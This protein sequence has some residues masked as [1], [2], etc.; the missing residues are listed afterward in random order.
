MFA[1]TKQARQPYIGTPIDDGAKLRLSQSIQIKTISGQDADAFSSFDQFLRQ[2]FELVFS[3]LE[4]AATKTNGLALIWHGSDPSLNPALWLAHKDVVP[5]EAAS[6]NQ[7]M[8]PP[9]S[10]VIDNQLIWGRGA[11]DDKSSVMA[12]F[13]SIN[14]AIKHGHAPKRTLYLFF[15]NDEEIGGELGAKAYANELAAKGL[16]FDY[17]LDEGG[18]IT[19]MVP[20]VA[21]AVALVGTTERGY[22]SLKLSTSDTGGHSSTPTAAPAVFRLASALSQLKDH[23]FNADLSDISGMMQAL[24]ND[25][26]WY[27]QVIFANQWL[28]APV[29]DRMMQSS[30]ALNAGIRTTIAPTMINAG[31]KDNV[32]PTYA[33]AV[34]NLRLF[35]GV[36]AENA[37]NTVTALIDDPSINIEPY[38]GDFGSEAPQA[39]ATNS[40]QFARLKG[41]I[42]RS[43]DGDIS[44]APRIVI[45]ATDIRHFVHL[46][47]NH[48]R[49]TAAEVDQSLIDGI[50][51]VNERISIKSYERMIRTYYQLL[52]SH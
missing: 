10:G 30:G 17:A 20:G 11:I 38:E 33:E 7:W 5:V 36:S 40:P 8:H 12:I 1:P 32:L 47:D 16:R 35:K 27:Y 29:I 6:I 42:E 15:G 26:P 4:E 52:T 25:L 24:A 3:N 41:A 39:S 14:M 22:L 31:V 9:F 13:E 2:H 50:H 46:T 45:G 49:F 37:I 48:Y 51:G 19:K 34:I 18:V 23:P 43:Y 21:S 28:F 44:V